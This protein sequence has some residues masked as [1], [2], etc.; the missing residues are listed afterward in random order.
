M[1]KMDS[2]WRNGKINVRTQVTF[3][4]AFK[5]FMYYISEGDTYQLISVFVMLNFIQ[6]NYNQ[7]ILLFWQ[8]NLKWDPM[9]L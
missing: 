1:F 2:W 4:I 7:I 5:C 9:G 8:I 6:Y 3:S